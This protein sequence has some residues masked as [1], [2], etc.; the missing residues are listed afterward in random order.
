MKTINVN[1]EIPNTCKK[2]MQDYCKFLTCFR[3]L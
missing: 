1:I 3:Q 2:T